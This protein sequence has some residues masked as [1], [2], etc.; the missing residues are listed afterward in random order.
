MS[1][2]DLARIFSEHQA[3]VNGGITL[4]DLSK[5]LAKVSEG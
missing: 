4:S 3:A 2:E 1:P 5:L